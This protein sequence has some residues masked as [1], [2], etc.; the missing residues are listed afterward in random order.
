MA[1]FG[2][3]VQSV[4][5]HLANLTSSRWRHVE[6]SS[7]VTVCSGAGRLISVTLNTN[8]GVVILRN[9]SEVIASIAAD[10]PEGTFYYGIYCN[11]SIICETGATADVTVNYD[12]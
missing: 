7:T 1:D 4:Q 5:K 11:A 12:I 9:G 3:K 8:G 6:A 10:A 2:R